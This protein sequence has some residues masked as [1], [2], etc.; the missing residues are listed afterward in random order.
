MAI[1]LMN[2]AIVNL[3]VV[4][5]EYDNDDAGLCWYLELFGC[6]VLE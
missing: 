3:L 2:N 4:I 1:E 6:W 5:I